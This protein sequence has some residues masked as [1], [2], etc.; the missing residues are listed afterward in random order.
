M[1]TVGTLGFSTFT[2]GFPFT[3]TY[4]TFHVGGLG[5]SVSGSF[6]GSDGGASSV[7]DGATSQ[8]V[9]V[10]LDACSSDSGLK[11]INFGFEDIM[12]Q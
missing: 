9:N 7:A 2:P 4:G 1:L 12:L 11:V 6:Q 3:G 10:L 5:V 8:D